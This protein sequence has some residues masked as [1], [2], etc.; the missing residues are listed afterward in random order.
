MRWRT[1]NLRRKRQANYPRD[2]WRKPTKATPIADILAL[3]G[4]TFEHSYLSDLFGKATPTDNGESKSHT[5]TFEPPKPVSFTISEGFLT[6]YG[7]GSCL[8]SVLHHIG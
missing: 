6:E 5:W 7:K 1:A 3:R 2:P 8:K 4:I